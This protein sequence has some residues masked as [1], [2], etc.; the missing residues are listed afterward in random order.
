MSDLISRKAV[1]EIVE[2]NYGD[3]AEVHMGVLDLP[4]I[5]P[6]K[7]EWIEVKPRGDTHYSKGYVKCSACNEIL[8][9]GWGMNF[10]LHCG[11]DM[12]KKV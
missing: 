5:E 4:T 11:A 9:S 2:N 6:P 1:L 12:R 10:C 3:I 8:W 7:G